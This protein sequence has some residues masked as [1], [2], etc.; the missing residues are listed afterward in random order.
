MAKWTD[1]A[2]LHF[3]A[4]ALPALIAYVDVQ[5][6]Y[7]YNNHAY[8]DWFGQS[9]EELY[10]KP[11][12]EVIGEPAYEMIRPHLAAALSGERVAFETQM[13]YRNAGMRQILAQYVPEFDETGQV[14][15]FVA[16]I[17]DITEKKQAEEA[18][19]VS[20]EQLEE[21][22]EILETVNRLGRLLSAELDLQK[23][24]Q[25]LTDAGTEIIS[26][27]HGSFFYNVLNEGGGYE[28]Y[29]LSGV[30][31]ERF[32]DFPMPRVT[33][34][35]SP[36]FHGQGV[37]RIDDVTRDARFGKNSPYQGLPPGHLPVASYLAVPVIARSGEVLGAL[38]FGHREP[39]VFTERHERII[40][41]LAGQA[42]IAI[43]NARLYEA[44]RKAR[45]E[46]EKANR[47]KDEFL[48]TVSHELRTPLN[49][50]LGW[51]R[52][53]R[54]G[55]LEAENVERALET[56]ERNAKAQQQ[57]VE[58]ILEVSRIITGKL[59]LDVA[60]VEI[61]PTIEAAVD[62]LRPTAE[63]KGVD[64]Q[65]VLDTKSSLVLG[66]TS[67]L[68]QVVWNLLSNAV[69]FTPKG[70]RVQVALERVNSHVRI[71]V[72]DTGQGIESQFLPYVFDRF[73]QADSSTA[74]PHGGLG[75]GLAIVRHL[76]ELHGG[77]VQ[78]ASS[79]ENL[80]AT[81]T[82]NLPLAII[83]EAGARAGAELTSPPRQSALESAAEQFV[84]E[85]TGLRVLVVD[86]EADARDL[87]TVVLRQYGVEVRGA[88]STRETLELLERW[89]P[90]VIISDIGMP[91]ED[92][93][94][95]I[96]RIR[97]LPE[98]RGGNIPAAALTAYARSEDR[99]KALAA[100]YQM[101]I[102]KPVEP[103]EL[104]AVVA[105]LARR[106]GR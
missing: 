56:I 30:P 22:R 102:A 76:V 16:L 4:D 55:K 96:R 97:S 26:A 31:R 105:S 83:R 47:L 62:S 1:A 38:L 75:L 51:S 54:M 77:T 73:R 2:R 24:V 32:A 3:I 60:P 14:R 46:A 18:L 87:L 72:S 88:G 57:I 36:T 45:Q 64:I 104:A 21:E 40:T 20:A 106:A 23:L 103:P 41:G 37:L 61:A 69:K 67:R 74:R 19:R 94:V 49:A 81:F 39:G 78:A 89:R 70:G 11:V 80:G 35:F 48:A 25:A 79:G 5:E 8:Q 93:Y 92:G 91:D 99:L 13:P 65:T 71:T 66:D 6:C 29:T 100:G 98:E 12:R 63:A 53:L 84:L 50:M 95:L 33:E 42:A 101:H 86:D 82:V 59:R 44:A 28:L 52:M 15:G 7:R 9:P 58:D 34:L 43:D 68:Q 85:L 17:N 90:D 27:Q 10:G